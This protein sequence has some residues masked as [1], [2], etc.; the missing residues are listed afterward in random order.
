MSF[1]ELF[2]SEFKHRNKG[3][4]AAIV[5]VALTD[6][7]ASPA[8]K[9]FL[10]KLAL[11]LEISSSEYEEICEN[12]S[13]YPIDPPYL[14]TERLE[15]LYDLARMVHVDHHLGDKQEKLLVRLGIALG[16]TPSNINYIVNKALSLVDK[17][18]DLDSFVYE[19]KNM[20]K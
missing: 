2:D 12:P 7:K 11:H 5:R 9:D 4:F 17:N 3:H 6:G 16:F 13:K 19:M 8:E 14:Y 20:Y 15:R 18:V 10:D 1:S